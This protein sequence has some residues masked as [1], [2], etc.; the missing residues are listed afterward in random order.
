MWYKGKIKDDCML[1]FHEIL[2][3]CH[4]PKDRGLLDALH[5]DIGVLGYVARCR[6]CKA[7]YV[8]DW[9]ESKDRLKRDGFMD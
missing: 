4:C 8:F 1:E 2:S 6:A 7:I 5:G 9:S 3:F